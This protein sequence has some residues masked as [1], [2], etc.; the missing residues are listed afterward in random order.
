MIDVDFDN[1]DLV[2]LE[3]AVL[4]AGN[5]MHA[6][7][8]LRPRVLE[9]ARMSATQKKTKQD[10]CRIVCNACI[11]LFRTFGLER[12]WAAN[13]QRCGGRLPYRIGAKF[14]FI[15]RFDCL[16]VCW[17]GRTSCHAGMVARRRVH[18]IAMQSTAHVA[19][20]DVSFSRYLR[21]FLTLLDKKYTCRCPL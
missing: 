4:D 7:Q 10:F 18:Q 17:L 19:P 13:G 21:L 6:S 11:S 2:A 1:D 3:A 20:R 5:L 14:Y 15:G 8:D 9:Q 12:R 16:R